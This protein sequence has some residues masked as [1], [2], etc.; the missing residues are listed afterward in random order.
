ML[1]GP[2]A[3]SPQLVRVRGDVRD[4]EPERIRID[5]VCVEGR[6]GVFAEPD[7]APDRRP[8]TC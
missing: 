2:L 6:L 7:V 8:L 3:R 5:D 1:W 4:F